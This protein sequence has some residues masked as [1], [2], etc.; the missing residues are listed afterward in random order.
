[1]R[2]ALAK[3]VLDVGKGDERDREVEAGVDEQ[4]RVCRQ[5]VRQT[6]G[7]DRSLERNN[8]ARRKE[9]GRREMV[10]RA[11]A[12]EVKGGVRRSFRS[13]PAGERTHRL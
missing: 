10:E 13:G 4:L 8:Q 12:A 7:R 3:V 9:E 11:S 2:A 5:A 6:V 1:L